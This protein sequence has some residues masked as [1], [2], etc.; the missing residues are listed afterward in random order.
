MP[1]ASQAICTSCSNWITNHFGKVKG[2]Y[3]NFMLT[4]FFKIV[5]FAKFLLS[6]SH[7]CQPCAC[8][9]M[10]HLQ[11]VTRKLSY[12]EN[13]KDLGMACHTLPLRKKKCHYHPQSYPIENWELGWDLGWVVALL[14]VFSCLLPFL[15]VQLACACELHMCNRHV[16]EPRLCCY[17]KMA[18]Y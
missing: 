11:G 5:G 13:R 3:Y 17:L 12:P 18:L 8:M 16:S 10:Y 2:S 7:I 1:H 15:S 9:I 6:R 14:L 4:Q